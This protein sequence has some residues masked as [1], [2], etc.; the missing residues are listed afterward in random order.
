MIKIFLYVSLIGIFLAGVAIYLTYYRPKVEYDKT[1]A[2]AGL[3]AEVSIIWDD[4]KVPHVFANADPDLYFAIGYIHAQER[5]WQM[6]LTQLGV[7]GRFAEFFGTRAIP[8]DRMSHTVGFREVAETIFEQLPDQEKQRL[9]RYADGVNFWV[10]E[11]PEQLPVEFSLFEFKPIAWSPIHSIGAWRLIAWEANASWKTDLT[12]AYLQKKNGDPGWRTFLPGTRAAI[13]SESPTDSLQVEADSTLVIPE[14]TQDSDSNTDA[15]AL[16]QWLDV[17]RQFLS[18]MGR[19]EG[20]FGSNAWVVN[21]RKSASG[22]PILVNDPH[23][24]LGLPS[25]WYEMH[26]NKNGQNLTGVTI[27][28][29]P[30]IING[31]N[32]SIA[33]AFTHLLSDQTDFFEEQLHPQNPDLFRTYGSDSLNYKPF[34]KVRKQ[35]KVKDS[36]DVVLTIRYT[37]QGP[38]IN[39]LV[40]NP[41]KPDRQILSMRWVG[42]QAGNELLALYELNWSD[43]LAKVTGWLPE[44]RVPGLSLMYADVSGN[45]AQ[46]ILGRFPIRTGDP[47]I[48]MPA[49]QQATTWSGYLSYNEL[50]RTIN[51]P[52]G[53]IVHANQPLE[54]NAYIGNF[55]EP[56]S[57]YRVIREALNAKASLTVDEL[58]AL[59]LE[60]LSA[61]ARDNTRIIVASISKSQRSKAINEALNYLINWDYRYDKAAAA[62]TIFE[63]TFN[64]IAKNT[65]KDELGEAGWKA[66]IR[67]DQLPLRL[68]SELLAGDSELFDNKQTPWRENRDSVIQRS[69]RESVRYL[70]DSLGTQT[71]QWRWE[72]VHS[73]VLQPPSIEALIPQAEWHH[74]DRIIQHQFVRGPFGMQGHTTSPINGQYRWDAPYEMIVG[75]SHRRIVDLSNLNQSWS[76]LPGG[77]SGNPLQDSYDNQLDQWIEGQYRLFEHAS[78]FR[79]K[80]NLPVTRLLPKQPE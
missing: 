79:F 8:A 69:M 28:G 45:I 61:H 5:L 24:S 75:A 10:S 31:H 6:T 38:L 16:T 29:I 27:P 74:I 21:A 56:D 22:F 78:D 17:H 4:D 48:P 68:T 77:Q 67:S 49:W 54:S 60:T 72:N 7:D 25:R 65:L 35:L 80:E 53:F 33:W 36:L 44:F 37:D 11:H 58:K 39:D 18:T 40:D 59:Q 41:I 62:A 34:K 55:Y 50:P 42:Q 70:I 73:L 9:Q 66:F 32:G 76:I 15:I 63:L 12:Y 46:F 71:I 1:L 52:E 13:P 43:R 51:P 26:V 2:I 23:Q 14:Q 47:V 20:H 30:Y 64:N 19:Q 57:R 3:D